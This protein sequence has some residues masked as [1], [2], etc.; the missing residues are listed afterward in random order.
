M[1]I[2]IKENGSVASEAAA[3][4]VARLV[5][6]KPNA[7]IGLA[8]GSTPL[9]LYKE[10]IRL[11]KEE[12]LDFS[13][14]STFNLDEYIG[15]E[16]DH[17]QSYHKFMWD[18]LFSHINIKPE[19]VHI[20]DGMAVDVPAFCAEYER[21][22]VEAGGIDLQVLG[23]GSDGH[24]GFNEPTSSFASRTRIKTL[25]QQTVAD[26]ARFFAGDESKVPHHCITMGIGTIMDAR[27]NIM[28][29]FGEGKAEAIAATVEGPVSSMMPASILQHHPSAKVF[30]DEGAASTLKLSD[31]YRWVYNGK[32]EWQRDA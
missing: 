32:P 24:V 22:I 5:R 10:M 9:V 26:N 23:I 16:K 6:E 31:Y 15:L 19:N 13:Q 25:T 30:I 4:V 18:N 14:V 2:I 29:A 21:K 1:E 11:H 20:P 28:L 17:E 8:T 3:R 7:V 12:G 27:M